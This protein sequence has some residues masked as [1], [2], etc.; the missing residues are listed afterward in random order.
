MA[1]SVGG[2]LGL[3]L[4][5]WEEL[6]ALPS[7]MDVIRGYRIP[8]IR[9]PP[10]TLPTPASFTVISRQ[11]H[12]DLVDAEVVALREKGAIEEVPLSS[13]GYFSR[14][15]LVPKPVGWRPIINLKKL[16]KF[17]IDCPHFRMDT[18]R[19]VALLLRP[20]DWA[21]SIDL[22]DAY[23]H[24][25]VD[26]S[27]RRFLRF[28]W[29]GRMW[30]FRVLPFGLCLAPLLFTKVTKTLKALL[31]LR[32]IRSIW[33]LDD[34]LIVGSSA[35]E[36]AAFVQEALLLIQRVGFIVN[37]P[38]SSLVPS[39][40]FRFLGLL[41]D[42]ASA[43][44]SIDEE[45]RLA[46][47]SRAAS[48][49]SGKMACRRLQSL[50]G[51]LAAVIP[52]VPL[53]R[54]HSRF[55]QRDLH[56]VYRQ[57]ED[58]N[59]LVLLSEESRQDLSWI[60]SLEPRQCA[61]PLWPLQ[62]EDCHLEV[63]TDASDEGWGIYFQGRLLQGP[64]TDVINA[65]AHINAK[66]LTAL[67]IFLRDFLPPSVDAR[68][69]LWRT[70]STTALAY[71]KNEGG[72]MSLP[73]LLL[74]R[75]VCLLAH[76]LRIR[77]LPVFIPTEENLHADAASRFQSLP[78]WHLPMETFRRICR[79]LGHPDIDLF[80]SAA[81]TQLPR[82]FAWGEAKE[83]EAFDALAQRWDFSL[84]YAFPPPPLLPRVLRKLAASPGV[85]L[86]VTPHWPSQKWF[87]AL[88]QLQV[89]AVFRLPDHPAVIDLTSGLPPPLPRLPL[90]VWRITG[91]FTASTSPTPPSPPSAAVGVDRLLDDTTQFGRA[92][93]P[94]C[95][96]EDFLSI[97]L[98]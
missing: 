60:A 96:P 9:P 61:A 94:F 65:P 41:W 43:T 63:A 35:A 78:D 2:R 91:G 12:V 40:L 90:L 19:D 74:A 18:V 38:K 89:E 8:F 76:S 92:S 84:A 26:P 83:A 28:G 57:A 13:P 42:T 22:K 95:M 73:L 23:F 15:F 71:V 66:E 64:W 21:A 33:Y 68:S 72:T 93:K 1:S 97:Q 86:L 36:C 80:A 14:L 34:I 85:F 52:A 4:H 7:V 5:V 55:L 79:R 27:S 31:H 87:P 77:I 48:A 11:D 88:L 59:R 16:N 98:I 81:S 39:Q 53:V 69:L 82:F 24:I 10:L 6:G 46:L 32:G 47:I 56:V 44:I 30:Q 45:K 50:L 51:H 17:F 25:P 75:E 3:F 49:T 62:M 70:D 54:L 67:L 29:R 37:F 58:I 20:G